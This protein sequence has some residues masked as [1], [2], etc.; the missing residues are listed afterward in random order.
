MACRAEGTVGAGST[1]LWSQVR[2]LL[3]T[4]LPRRQLARVRSRSELLSLIRPH[5]GE[6]ELLAE[7]A[8]HAV[9]ICLEAEAAFYT[10]GCRLWMVEVEVERC[11][12]LSLGH[13]P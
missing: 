4:V 1:S 10:G 11:S 5:L 2:V 9:A 7:V 12:A 3:T 6:A 13:G 8:R